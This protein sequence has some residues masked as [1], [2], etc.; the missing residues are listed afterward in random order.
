MN[1]SS[2]AKGTVSYSDASDCMGGVPIEEWLGS[3][4]DLPVG[5]IVVEKFPNP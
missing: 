4:F 3:S 1:I 5:A 2:A